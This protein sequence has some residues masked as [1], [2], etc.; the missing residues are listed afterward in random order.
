MKNPTVRARYA[1]VRDLLG[2][3]YSI[4]NNWSVRGDEIMAPGSSLDAYA[5]GVQYFL[6]LAKALAKTKLNA[7]QLQFYVTASAGM[8]RY[9]PP[10][11]GLI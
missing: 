11:G 3:T 6:P 7:N 8:D 2:Q 10:A 9:T 5:G 1:V 4:T